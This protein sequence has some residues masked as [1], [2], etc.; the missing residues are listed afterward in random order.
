MQRFK[1]KAVKEMSLRFKRTIEKG[2]SELNID[3]SLLV[4]LSSFVSKVIL[5]SHKATS[6]FIWVLLLIFQEF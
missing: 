4:I 1:D 6:K 3:R 5:K 2:L